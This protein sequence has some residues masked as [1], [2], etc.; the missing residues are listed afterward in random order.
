M[1]LVATGGGL[2]FGGDVAGVFRALDA[3]TGKVLW[4]TQLAGMVSGIPISYSAG[5]KQFVA[6]ATGPS[7]NG[8]GLAALTKDIHAGTERVLHVFAVE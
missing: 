6:V 8:S 2:V 1:G 5:G 3:K 4:Q 7:S